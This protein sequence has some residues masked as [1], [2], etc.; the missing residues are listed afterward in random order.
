MLSLSDTRCQALRLRAPRRPRFL[1]LDFGERQARIPNPC[2]DV[3]RTFV[4]GR[5]VGIARG[6]HVAANRAGILQAGQLQP[7]AAPKKLSRGV[8]S[9]YRYLREKRSK[10]AI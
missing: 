1:T 9:S 10:S 2:L 7:A 6:L 4:V 5:R 3:G 8:F